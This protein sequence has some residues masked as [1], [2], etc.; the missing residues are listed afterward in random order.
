MLSIVHGQGAPNLDRLTS[1]RKN[2][3]VLQGSSVPRLALHERSQLFQVG[4]LVLGLVAVGSRRLSAARS[5]GGLDGA[6]SRLA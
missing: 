4:R 5:L 3:A 6:G 2:C 1:G